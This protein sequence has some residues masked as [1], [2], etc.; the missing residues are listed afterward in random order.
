MSLARVAPEEAPELPTLDNE[1][2]RVLAMLAANDT[3]DQIRNTTGWSRGRIYNLACRMGARKTESRIRE[4]A[5][6]RKERQREALEA[7]MNE[8][9][10]ADVHDF[11]DALPDASAQLVI[12]SPPYNLG[13]TYGG[14]PGADRMRHLYY[15]GW[16]MTIVSEVARILTPGGVCFLQVGTTRDDANARVPLDILAYPWLREAGLDFQNRIAWIAQHGLTPRRR[17]AERY[18]TALVFSKGEP[19]F[20]PNAARIPQKQPNKRAFKGPRKGELSGHPL[21][22]APSDVWTIPHIGHNHPDLTDHPAAFPVSLA[23]RAVLLYSLPGDLVVDPFSGSGS[24]QLAALACGRRFVGADL[25]YHD[26]REARLAKA[27]PDL[28][29]PL[30]GVTDESV[31]VWQAEAIRREV[32]AK[33]ISESDEEQMLLDLFS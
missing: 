31:A 10:S 17:L 22:A 20:N 30:S 8:T 12:F 18:E 6:E 4:R 19:R 16:M 25:F 14:L 7:L 11:L 21:G 29:T 2:I 26:I 27:A 5:K 9:A 15:Q 28:F 32:P 33:P 3:Y 24:T 1:S 23:R 13:K